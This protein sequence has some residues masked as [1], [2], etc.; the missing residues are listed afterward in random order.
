MRMLFH[1]AITA[2][3]IAGAASLCAAASGA[4]PSRTFNFDYRVV[5]TDLP[6]GAD[7]RI[8]IPVAQTTPDQQV[9]LLSVPA[10]GQL[11][12]EKTYGNR[13][14]YVS[15]TSAGEDLPLHLSYRV[16]RFQDRGDAPADSDRAASRFL[17]PDN[18]VPVGGKAVALIA[19]RV[20]PKNDI[21]RARLI[22]D[23]VDD[24]MVY[25]KDKPGWGTGNSEWAYQSC[26]GNCTD[27]HSLFI[28]LARA[29]HIP[30]K[31]EIGF[32]LGEQRNG[33]IPGYHCWAKFKPAGHGW[34]PVDI[35]D[36][37]QHPEKREANFGT[38]DQNRIMLSTGRDIVLEPRQAGGPVNFLVYPYVEV[39]GKPLP[40]DRINKSFSYE[41]V[42]A[43]AS[44]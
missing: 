14:L 23:A 6:K 7:V 19:G 11:T 9:D 28:S 20:L 43:T 1:A 41:D 22:Y 35:S 2:L 10:G 38:I 37:N 40:Q 3:A 30:A 34:M 17:K 26:F 36:A 29:E 39:D 16:T 21:E 12:T 33:T 42:T 8:W 18:L 24:H 13:L 31:F 5:V 44:E 27:F 4:R 15:H 32:M 25:R